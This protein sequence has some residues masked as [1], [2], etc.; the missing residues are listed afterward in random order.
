MATF[1][2][3]WALFLQFIVHSSMDCL[4]LLR[5]KKPLLVGK[6]AVVCMQIALGDKASI[7][8][9]PYCHSTSLGSHAP[10]SNNSVWFL[11]IFFFC[12]S[13]LL[14]VICLSLSV[15]LDHWPLSGRPSSNKQK[16][17]RWGRFCCRTAQR[18]STLTSVW[19]R[20][21]SMK[22]PTRNSQIDSSTEAERQR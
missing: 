22:S 13:L 17:D 8:C 9:S 12:F 18:T 3:F 6:L 5:C 20:H 4:K 2:A 16:R 7:T 15:S 14:S 10:S 21:H 1:S 11:S 19:V